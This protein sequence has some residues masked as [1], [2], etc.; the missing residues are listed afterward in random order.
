MPVSRSSKTGKAILLVADD[1]ASIQRDTCLA[2]SN[3]SRALRWNN[4]LMLYV[5]R[6]LR[7]P[8]PQ[9]LKVESKGS[10][11]GLVR[12]P[13]GA[14]GQRTLYSECCPPGPSL[15]SFF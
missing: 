10:L 14:S 1:D 9:R 8:T 12:N 6:T 2:T 7:R 11:E 3:G 4:L 15:S 5:E 13:L